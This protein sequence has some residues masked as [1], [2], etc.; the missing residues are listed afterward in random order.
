MQRTRAL[1]CRYVSTRAARSV[2]QARP[3]LC[4]VCTRRSAPALRGQWWSRLWASFQEPVCDS[5]PQQ[6]AFAGPDFWKTYLKNRRPL[7]AE[8]VYELEDA[9]ARVGYT[10]PQAR[11]VVEAVAAASKFKGDLA[12]LHG[13]L[14]AVHGLQNALQPK[15]PQEDAQAFAEAV[16]YLVAPLAKG[17]S[18]F[19]RWE[20]AYDALK[21]CSR[22]RFSAG[23]ASAMQAIVDAEV[24]ASDQE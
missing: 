7:N 8:V 16:V 20:Q 21:R 9:L 14:K 19:D 13:L 17:D 10:R 4:N 5:L 18:D 12:T 6:L 1:L 24:K 23:V 3:P 22:L 2:R 11:L 15:L